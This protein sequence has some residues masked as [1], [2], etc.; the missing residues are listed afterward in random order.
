MIFNL[1]TL[2]THWV[3]DNH[4]LLRPLLHA[5]TFVYTGAK[6]LM[7]MKNTRDRLYNVLLG[8]HLIYGKD[9]RL[10]HFALPQLRGTSHPSYKVHIDKFIEISLREKTFYRI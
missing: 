3:I 1:K 6:K 8:N 9:C 10:V 5:L 4:Q 2:I 7:M